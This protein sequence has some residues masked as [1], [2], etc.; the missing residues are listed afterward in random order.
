MRGKKGTE[1]DGLGTYDLE[2]TT[3]LRFSASSQAERA[4]MPA[5]GGGAFTSEGLDKVPP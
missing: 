3:E 4:V 1:Y 5:D 2:A